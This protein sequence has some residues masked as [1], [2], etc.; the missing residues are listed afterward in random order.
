[1]YICIWYIFICI[2]VYTLTECFR[3]VY[4]YV[5]HTYLY[6]VASISRLLKMIGIFCK[7]A[8]WKTLYS[9]KE[10]YNFKEPTDRSH[11]IYIYVY[12]TYSY[13]YMYTLLRNVFARKMYIFIMYMYVYVYV[14]I[15]IHMNCA[16]IDIN[17][18]TIVVQ[19]YIYTNCAWVD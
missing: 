9:A 3:Q 10:T 4:I 6:G 18:Y 17:K 1:M 11:P 7:R 12:R 2:Y 8:L 5:Y 16:W 19:V 13:V 14:Y 15:Y